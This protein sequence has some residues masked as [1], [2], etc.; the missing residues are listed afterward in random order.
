MEKFWRKLTIRR[1]L[2]DLV[3]NLDMGPERATPMEGRW[4]SVSPG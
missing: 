4:T 3:P 2:F 1:N